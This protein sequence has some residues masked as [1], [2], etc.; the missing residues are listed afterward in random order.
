MA[1]VLVLA[2]LGAVVFFAS[3]G[4]TK[5]VEPPAPPPET[6]QPAPVETAP[7]EKPRMPPPPLPAHLQEQARELVKQARSLKTQGEAVYKEAS[8]AK[9]AGDEDLWQAK[10]REAAGYFQQIKDGYNALLEQVPGN[11]DWD[12]EEVAN[13]YLGN[14][15]DSIS[16]ALGRLFDIQKQRRR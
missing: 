14:E 2:V 1:A 6:I 9:Q 12:E 5:R 3:Q 16:R 15:A 4:K 11:D 7:G 13:H 8:A 10:L